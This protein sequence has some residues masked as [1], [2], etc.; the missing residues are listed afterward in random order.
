LLSTVAGAQEEEKTRGFKKENLF[1]GGSVSLGLSNRSFLIGV[2]PHFGYSLTRWAD[3]GVTVNYNYSS[4]RDYT[5]F[6]DKLR[7]SV[8]GGGAFTRLFP[9]RFLFAQAQW[10]RN[11][12]DL[13][14]FPGDVGSSYSDR[15]SA[16]SLLLGAGY[17]TGRDPDGKS[18]YGYLSVLFDV[19]KNEYS[20]Y[21]DSRNR[22]LPIIR[23]GINVPLFTGKR[24][25]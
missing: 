11:W 8:Y 15:V 6:G 24:N 16:S 13:K 20:P 12:I 1:T 9:V 18:V 3:L 14:Y 25:F 17:S 7:Q 10:E 5:Y 19:T 2:N 4:F 22:A 23:A 21:I